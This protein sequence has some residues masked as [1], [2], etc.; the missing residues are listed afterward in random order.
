MLLAV[1]SAKPALTE[2]FKP[3]PVQASLSLQL[4]P[5][6]SAEPSFVSRRESTSA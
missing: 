3:W 1:S 2:V 4:L 6:P 5:H